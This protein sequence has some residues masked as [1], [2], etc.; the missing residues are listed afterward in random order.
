MG[1]ESF[2]RRWDL[3]LRPRDEIGT[4][5]V[6]GDLTQL[7]EAAFIPVNSPVGL[8]TRWPVLRKMKVQNSQRDHD[9]ITSESMR[10]AFDIWDSNF[11]LNIKWRANTV[12]ENVHRSTHEAQVYFYFYFI[13]HIIIAHISMQTMCSITNMLYFCFGGSRDDNRITDS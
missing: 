2:C 8:R 6:A 4:A 1:T 5:F 11:T 9:G 12:A 7:T 10:S 3:S 13:K